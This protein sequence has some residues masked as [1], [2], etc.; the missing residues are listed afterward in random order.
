[1]FISTDNGTVRGLVGDI[2]AVRL[3]G[4]AGFNGIDF[5]FYEMKP[6]RNVLALSHDE[7]YAAAMNIREK[8]EKYHLVFPQTHAPYDYCYGEGKD[9]VHYQEV[10]KSLEFSSWLGCKQVVIHTLKFVDGTTQERSDEINREFMRSFLPYAEKYDVNIGV[11][12]L[13]KPDIK[14][15]CFTGQHETPEKMNAFVDSLESNRF[16]VCC[17]LGHAAITGVEPQ[18]FILGMNAGRMTM[19]HV[20]DTNYLD[21]SHTIPFLGLHEWD[22]ITDALA[23][24]NYEGFINLEVLHFYERF[25]QAMIPAALSMARESAAYLASQVEQKKQALAKI[26]TSRN[27]GND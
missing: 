11:E 9:S 3:I 23:Q 4:E 26:S 25:P 5:T 18:D 1:M 12:N 22:K 8:A 14:R 15:H 27:T 2:E 6:E 10:I 13:F 7:R 21:D 20:Q 17:D 19:L 16:R 24:I